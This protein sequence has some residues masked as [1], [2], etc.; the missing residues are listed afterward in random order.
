MWVQSYSNLLTVVNG[1][2]VCM[3]NLCAPL[4]STLYNQ[5]S[6]MSVNPYYIYFSRATDCYIALFPTIYTR[7]WCVQ[8]MDR[9]WRQN[10]QNVF[11]ILSSLFYYNIWVISMHTITPNIMSSWVNLILK[12][13]FEAWKWRCFAMV[14]QSLTIWNYFQISRP[15]YV[16]HNWPIRMTY[17]KVLFLKRGITALVKLLRKCDLQTSVNTLLNLITSFATGYPLFTICVVLFQHRVSGAQCRT[18]T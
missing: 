7:W 5:H 12:F 17:L 16:K 18:V 14:K 2:N 15:I 4:R 8:K 11:N 3:T 1:W 6:P 13:D 9:R 10:S